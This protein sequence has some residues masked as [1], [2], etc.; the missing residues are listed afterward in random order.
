M[1]IGL[2]GKYCAGKNAAA[3]V[4]E[5]LNIPSIDVDKLGHMALD[6]QINRI[7]EA[8]GS[9]VIVKSEP[10][11]RSNPAKTVNRKELGAIVFSD[12]EKLRVLELI[13]H[14]WMVEETERRIAEFLQCGSTHVVINAAVLLKMGLHQLC[15]TVLWVDA[16]LFI[17]IRR[18]LSRDPLKLPAVL[19]RIYT[20][21]TLKPQP[22]G[23]YVDIYKVDNRS[24]IDQLRMEIRKILG[25]L[26]QKGSNGR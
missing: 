21:R 5:E 10:N 12:P 9:G 4:F 11:N 22:L 6:A 18:G 26:E 20:Q 25:Q 14:P 16:P 7:E 15:D 1:I 13:T 3:S 19:K 23:K 17:R 8:F 2:S 24:G